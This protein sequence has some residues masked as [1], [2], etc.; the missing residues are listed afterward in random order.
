MIIKYKNSNG[1]LTELH[2]NSKE[3]VG[4]AA[5][6]IGNIPTIDLSGKVDKATGKDLLLTTE[7][8]K[9][10]V[11]NTDNQLVN[12]AHSVNLDS[13]GNLHV[14]NI[15]QQGT[16]Y[17][18]H[19][20]Q[21]STTK[22]ELILREGAIAGLVNGATT[23]LRAKLYDGVNDGL[24]EFDN[25]GIARVGDAGNTQPI[26]TREETP[27][28]GGFAFWDALT[29][30]FK[31][32]AINVASIMSHLVNVLNPHS[33]T[34]TQV[35][36]GNVPNL[37]FSGSNTGDQT[38]LSLGGEPSISKSTGFLT[39]TGSVWAWITTPYTLTKAAIEAVFTG[40]IATHTH[41]VDLSSV[42]NETT[43]SIA[44]IAHNATVKTTLVDTDETTGTDS[45]SGFEL[46]RTTWLNVWNYIKGKSDVKYAAQNGG[47]IYHTIPWINTGTISTSGLNVT[48]VSTVFTAAMVGAKIIVNLEERIIATYTDATHITVNST[49]SQ[50][51]SNIGFRIYSISIATLSDGSIIWKPYS[52]STTLSMTTGGSLISNDVL[53]FGTR[54]R[55]YD[56]IQIANNI[57]LLWSATTSY[58]GTKDLG[59]Q[60]IATG[61]LSIFDSVI[62]GNY[63]DLALRYIY[64]SIGTSIGDAI[65]DI[66]HSNQAGVMLFEKCTVGNAVKGSGTWVSLYSITALG[67]VK[68]TVVEYASN[69]AATTAGLAVGTHYRTGEFLKIVY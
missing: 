31:T 33:V 59:L 53:A 24:L 12:G 6:L 25:N 38:L 57:P 11:Q 49:F 37:T 22:D 13:A 16:S 5:Q 44:A 58:S 2:D 29:F 9:I 28:D 19:A 66:R 43:T 1:T 55:L 26:S 27:I 39:W 54:I 48:V 60:R 42:P 47:I 7:A 4:V 50:S 10:H 36:L 23:G 21:I 64:Q 34:K 30:K 3:N 62:L 65:G 17:E 52:G 67:A 63:R 20:E 14:E 51:Y 40:N 56:S 35:G 61:I 15:V 69:E 45:A 41:T 18:T 8:A 32:V 46:I 68:E